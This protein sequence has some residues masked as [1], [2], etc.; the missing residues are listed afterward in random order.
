[1]NPPANLDATNGEGHGSPQAQATVNL[2]A[3]MGLDGLWAKI[4]NFSA[5][6]IISGLAIVTIIWTRQ[7]NKEAVRDG[8]EAAKEAHKSF[9]DDATRTRE[10]MQKQW[11]E[12]R[13]QGETN[14]KALLI[15]TELQKDIRDH[16]KILE[17]SMRSN[18]ELVGE[19]KKAINETTLV[20]KEILLEIKRT[21]DKRDKDKP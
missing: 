7:D 11:D 6:V 20:N 12:V 4:A 15:G 5:V 18:A 10:Q 2:P 16:Q 21:N 14:Q 8:R 3:S 1:M 17:A 19:V 13:K 9:L